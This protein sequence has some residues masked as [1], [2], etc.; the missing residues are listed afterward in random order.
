MNGQTHYH[1]GAEIIAVL[2]IPSI[3]ITGEN[4]HRVG[5][6][7]IRR[8]FGADA[9]IGLGIFMD[10]SHTNPGANPAAGI[11]QSSG[12]NQGF[13][14]VGGRNQNIAIGKD[15][16]VVA[17]AGV[18]I[19]LNIHHRDRAAHGETAARQADGN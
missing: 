8:N 11:A 5:R 1:L 15:R 18:G 12:N 2:V 16:S 9:D 17:D 4:G 3:I 10:Q 13:G 14:N 7:A 6:I 19:R